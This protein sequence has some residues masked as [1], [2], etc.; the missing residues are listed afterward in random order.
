MSKGKNTLK[1]AAAGASAGA[2]A[3]PW[4]AAIGGGLGAIGGYM[5][6][7]GGE[8]DGSDAEAKRLEEIE[9]AKAQLSYMQE[10]G[11]K[12]RSA[13]IQNLGGMYLPLNDRLARLYG[14]GARVKMPT[15]NTPIEKL[16]Q[17]QPGMTRRP[18]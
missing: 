8:D 11:T 6:L 12:Q 15:A 1:G 13:T 5:G 18:K 10:L 9:K 2:A 7:F 4:G 14:D 16:Y 17:Q 3:G